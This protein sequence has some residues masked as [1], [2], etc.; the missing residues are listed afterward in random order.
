MNANHTVE[1]ARPQSRHTCV[2]TD[3]QNA[4]I[5]P[6]AALAKTQA[7]QRIV[8]ADNQASLRRK[9]FKDATISTTKLQHRISRPDS[10]DNMSDLS[11]QVLPDP[12]R[13]Q[14]VSLLEPIGCQ[15]ITVVTV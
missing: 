10:A 5:M 12:W 3:P 8:D 11:F 13:C 15:I 4:G 9:P 7:C 6:T 1:R 2:S 14:V